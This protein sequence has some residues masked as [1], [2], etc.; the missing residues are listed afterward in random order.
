M[1]DPPSAF[2]TVLQRALLALTAVLIALGW[3]LTQRRTHLPLTAGP[4]VARSNL[5]LRANCWYWPR[6]TN[7]FTGWIVENYPNGRLRSRMAVANGL[8]NGPCESWFD[9]GQIQSREFFRNG[10]SDGPRQTWYRNG[11]IETRAEIVNGKMEGIF[12]RWYDNG[13]L[14]EMIP[15]NNGRPDGI[16]RAFY[17]SGCAKAETRVRAGQVIVRTVWADGERRLAD[18]P[19]APVNRT[20]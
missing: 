15:M 12:R 4:T 3:F 7:R 16:A 19:S 1:S 20:N 6:N 11:R 13:R 14:A 18:P 9:N 10:V 8:L 2:R 5:V 17:P